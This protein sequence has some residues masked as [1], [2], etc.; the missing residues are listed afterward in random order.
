MACRPGQRGKAK[1]AGWIVDEVESRG[2]AADRRRPAEGEALLVGTEG[3]RAVLYL[4][5][6]TGDFGP[7]RVDRE[8]RAAKPPRPECLRW[9]EPTGLW[10]LPVRLG[11]GRRQGMQPGKIDLA[12]VYID[13]GIG[14]SA[15]G[16]PEHRLAGKLAATNLE[17]RDLDL[18]AVAQRKGLGGEGVGAT[19]RQRETKVRSQHGEIASLGRD[20]QVGALLRTDRP[21]DRNVAVTQAAL[22]VNVAGQPPHPAVERPDPAR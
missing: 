20:L 17:R 10:R 19:A 12:R 1:A 11:G 7:A 21:F 8:L 18:E 2:A 13:G 4:A 22:H 3:N 9:K 15:A 14:R 16:H 5:G 6:K